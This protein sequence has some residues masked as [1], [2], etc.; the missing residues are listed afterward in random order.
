M[1]VMLVVSMLVI[2]ANKATMVNGKF[3]IEHEYE[4]A[5]ANMAQDFIDEAKVHMFDEL[6]T[7]GMG[8]PIP[9]LDQIA[10]AEALLGPDAG[11][12]TRANFDDFDDFDGYT[13]TVNTIHGEF[14]ISIRVRYVD[15][16]QNPS[17]SRTTMKQITVRLTNESLFKD[18][19]DSLTVYQFEF[20]KSIYS[21]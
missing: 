18:D 3:V 20:V 6:S 9:D 5:V 7:P 2:N 10:T 12:S 4:A 15:I 13:E 19:P 8:G 11:E 21:D 16:D 1:A 14:E 17:A